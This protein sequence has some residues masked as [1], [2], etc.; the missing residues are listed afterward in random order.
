MGKPLI[1]QDILAR[2]DAAFKSITTGD[3]GSTKLTPEKAERFVRAVEKATPMLRE[4]RMLEMKSDTRDIDKT[5]FGGRIM[6]AAVEDTAPVGS[7]KP[8]FST[9]KLVAVE[10]IAVVGISDSALEDNIEGEDFENTL[11]DMM[12]ERAGVDMEELYIKGDT[13]SGDT[14]LA[15]TDGWN[16]L[17][18]NAVTGTVTDT[19]GGMNTTLA[20]A[21]GAGTAILNVTS[22]AN[23]A[24]GDWIRVG[25]GWTQE[26]REIAAVNANALT[27]TEPLTNNHQAGEA[28]V[29]IDAEPDF[30]PYSPEAMFQAMLNVVPQ[31][32]LRER[33]EWRFWVAPEIE[34]AYR[35][36]LRARGTALGDA[37]QTQAQPVAYKGIPVVPVGN[38]PAGSGLL[39]HPDNLVYGI[40]RDVRIERDRQPKARRTDFVLTVRTDAHFEDTDAVVHASGWRG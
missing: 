17:S 32:Y 34:D 6:Q 1:P 30:N 14:Y 33:G 2:L 27:L 21:A 28:A 10:A 13:T 36:Q 31:K 5:G 22:A 9:N 11:I 35:D 8:N 26:Y 37:A 16:K 20:Q 25:A 23:G 39:G 38:M 18:G 15:L 29:E 19:A 4:A 7:S 40:K 3:L 24:V 12:G